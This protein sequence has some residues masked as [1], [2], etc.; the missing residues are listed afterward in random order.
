MSFACLRYEHDLAVLLDRERRD[1]LAGLLVVFMLMT[2]MPP[3]F[4]RR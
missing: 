3:R 4:V 1:D 2:P